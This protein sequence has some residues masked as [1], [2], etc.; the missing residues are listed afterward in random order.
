MG[1][2]VILH[3]EN[4]FVYQVLEDRLVHQENVVM[5]ICAIQTWVHQIV[6]AA[7]MIWLAQEVL[8]NARQL[9]GQKGVVGQNLVVNHVRRVLTVVSVIQRQEYAIVNP[10]GA[11]QHVLRGCVQT[12]KR[13]AI[14]IL[15]SVNAVQEEAHVP[16]HQTVAK[17]LVFQNA[18]LNV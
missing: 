6:N 3:L 10:V 16:I 15:L 12:E 5:E 1:A 7:V 18:R 4:V 2:P 17:P 13:F 14:L 9:P 11:T 8:Q